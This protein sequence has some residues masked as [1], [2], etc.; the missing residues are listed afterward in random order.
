MDPHLAKILGIAP[1]RKAP[2]TE[3]APALDLDAQAKI[4]SGYHGLGFPKVSRSGNKLAVDFHNRAIVVIAEE[5]KS[6]TAALGRVDRDLR[7]E[8]RT[9]RM[10]GITRLSALAIQARLQ[11][12][13]KP[14]AM[15]VFE[16]RKV[17]ESVMNRRPENLTQALLWQ[18]RVSEVRRQVEQ[19]SQS[20]AITAA[21]AL[22]NRGDEVFPEVFLNGLKPLIPDDIATRLTADYQNALVAPAV[23]TLEQTESALDE[24]KAVL[25]CTDIALGASLTS[26]GI[27]PQEWRDFSV[28]ACVKAWPQDA[29][30]SFIAAKGEDA[31]TDLLRGTVDLDIALDVFRPGLVEGE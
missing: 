12:A 1:R 11:E 14:L 7:S 23:A 22:A 18:M 3:P 29:K 13:A 25:G 17:I 16:A 4:N 21:I 26:A 8:V 24:V 27:L 6:S 30:A 31:Y 20:D 28:M 9:A 5:A 19:M 2:R 15:K 10:A